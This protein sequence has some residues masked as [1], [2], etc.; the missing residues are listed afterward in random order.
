V[1]PASTSDGDSESEEAS[2]SKAGRK[3]RPRPKPVHLPGG[4]TV[5][6]PT[7]T[8]VE[9]GGKIT[10]VA[11]TAFSCQENVIIAGFLA[12]SSKTGPIAESI[13]HDHGVL[14]L[15]IVIEVG[16]PLAY[17]IVTATGKESGRYCGP[18]IFI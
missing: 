10:V 15:L 8:G 11:S 12:S 17:C 1:S 2:A 18:V 5:S 6:A 4:C 14:N 13:W 7:G 9:A 16:E 3:P